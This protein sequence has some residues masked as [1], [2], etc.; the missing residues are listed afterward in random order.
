MDYFCTTIHHC[1]FID[2]SCFG[3]PFTWSR[4]HPTEGRIHIRL[5]QALANTKWK[6]HF[7]NAIV[8]HVSMS[9]SNH[10]M[11]AIRLQHPRPYQ[12]CS[13]P[14]FRFKIIWLQDPKCAK[15][16][17]EAWHEFLYKPDGVS[18]INCHARCR[19]Q[20]T[21]WNKLEFG[22]IGNKIARLN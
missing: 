7:P 10:S 8:H 3:S 21:V 5:D 18:I 11:L 15:I 14:L 4:N 19:D 1:N 22:Y 17:Q 13:R 6:S 12:P 20:L 9:S 16:V 2:L